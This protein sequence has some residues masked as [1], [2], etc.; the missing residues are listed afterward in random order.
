MRLKLSLTVRISTG[1]VAG[2]G[3][4][5][6][7]PAELFGRNGEPR[8]RPVDDPGDQYRAEH[9]KQQRDRGPADPLR[10]DV[11]RDR[12]ALD[13][14]PVAILVDREADPYPFDAVHLRCNAGC[15]VRAARRSVGPRAAAANARA[16]APR[17]RRA[18]AAQSGCPRCS[19]VRPAGRAG[20][21]DR[22]RQARRGSV[23]R[24]TRSAARWSPRA[25]P[26]RTRGSSAAR[27]PG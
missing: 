7:S 12:I 18:R 25:G 3:G 11:A 19:R 9:R 22:H 24:S 27:P 10:A 1:P 26:A 14:E 21:R 16:A 4:R 15:R 23:A 17:H 6:L 13:V 5:S 20:R 8:Q 2:S